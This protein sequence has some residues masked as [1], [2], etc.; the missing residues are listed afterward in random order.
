VTV[1]VRRPDNP[2]RVA[3]RVPV[4]VEEGK[5][6][7]L[8]IT[9]PPLREAISITVVD[10]ENDPVELAE[11]NVLSLDPSEPLRTTGFS[12]RD[13]KLEVPDAAGLQL[14]V[15]AQAPGFARQTLVVAASDA[16]GTLAVKLPRGA[17]VKGRVTALR[18][19]RGVEGALV[20]LS[21][22]GLRKTATTNA[23][24]DYQ[25]EDVALGPVKLHVSHPDF[26]DASAE[27]KIES[28]G[29]RD[30]A[31]E[32]PSIDLEEPGAV[33][34]EVLDERGD[35]VAGARVATGRAPTYLPA[36]TLPRGVAVTDA[37]G[38][39]SLQGLP[40]GVVT[41]DAFSPDRGRG[42]VKVEVR[43]GRTESGLRINLRQSGSEQD[44]FAPAGVAITLGERGA[45]AALEIVVVAVAENSE[46]ERAGIQAGDVITSVDDA[47]VAS[48]QDARLR[49][50][51]PARSDVVV[52]VS[53]AGA[54]QRLSVLREAVRK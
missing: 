29:R 5:K 19:R 47:K 9:L 37:R 38:A 32:L 24:G 52:T 23:D 2:S 17:L 53:R 25:L 7:T 21:S 12:D 31:F 54:A 41:I 16:K 30:R 22:Q 18:G 51:G 35:P 8:E 50:S 6:E 14:R 34:G 36:G 27:A 20:T 39:F 15:S 43:S 4:R 49:L 45:G 1:N 33:E 48:M 26:A 11:I 10:E 13:G 44:P 46:A 28:P 42:S 3:K 40:S